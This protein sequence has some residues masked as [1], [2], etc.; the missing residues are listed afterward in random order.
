MG[1]AA[2]HENGKDFLICD[3]LIL[4]CLLIIG[5]NNLFE[6]QETTL[7][8][9]NFTSSYV[10]CWFSVVFSLPVSEPYFALTCLQ[11]P[12]PLKSLLKHPLCICPTS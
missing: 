12:Y 9:L 7:N 2:K 10:C 11:R 6:F 4:K 5:Y 1:S 8:K 3:I